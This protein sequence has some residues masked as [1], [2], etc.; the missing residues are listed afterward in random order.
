MIKVLIAEFE[1]DNIRKIKTHIKQLSKADFKVVKAIKFSSLDIF[2]II[3]ET[4]PELIIMNVRFFG[5]HSFKI[6][7]DIHKKHEDIRFIFCGNYDDMDYLQ[8]SY[9]LGSLGYFLAPFRMAELTPLLENAKRHF[10]ATAQKRQEKANLRSEYA[11]NRNLFENYFVNNLLK[12]TINDYTE[13]INNFKYFNM[14]MEMPYAAVSIRVN[15]F[16]TKMLSMDEEEKNIFIFKLLNTIRRSLAGVKSISAMTS[17]NAIALIIGGV[18][19]QEELL[20]I[21]EN[22]KDT[23]KKENNVNISMGIG[24]IYEDISEISVSYNE[25]QGAIKHKFYLGYSTIIPLSYVEP[26]NVITYRYPHYK[27]QRLIHTAVA[28][29]FKYCQTLLADIFSSL[30]QVSGEIPDRL[31]PQIIVNIFISISR[32]SLEQNLLK[33]V[34]FNEFFPI[35]RAITVKTL[36]E[37]HALLYE[38]LEKFCQFVSTERKNRN[39]HILQNIKNHLQEHYYETISK[40]AVAKKV[41]T[42]PEYINDLFLKHEG[43]SFYDY[44]MA[45]R[46]NVAKQFLRDTDLKDSVIAVNVG[47]SDER[48]FRSI[49]MQYEKMST[50]DYRLMNKLNKSQG[51][52][53]QE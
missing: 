14:N 27:E 47:Y 44:V 21:C 15:D 39:Y 52:P 26:E 38:C 8:S 25:A 32:H 23:V 17:F 2:D 11:K 51:M 22:V 29:E 41:G 30:D 37:G 45:I 10:D 3:E 46:L 48:Y 28:G 33:S 50:D 31:L 18:N 6:I 19:D 36:Q 7:S 9:K 20:K 13:I 24:R 49:F 4:E 40:G 12:G 42:T 5:A 53:Q 34:N 35:N 16:K 1:E 43:Q